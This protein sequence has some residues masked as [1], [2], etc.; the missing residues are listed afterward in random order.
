MS[1]LANFN[2]YAQKDTFEKE[3]S[4]NLIDNSSISFIKDTKQI[5]THEQ[6]Y[7]GVSWKN[8]GKDPFNGYEYVDMGD[9]GIWATCNIGATQPHEYG[10]YFAWGETKGYESAEDKEG[11]FTWE[12]TPYWVS[13]TTNGSSTKWSKYTTIDS[14]S[15]IGIA[16][17]KLILDLEDDAAH[18]NMG[19]DWRMPTRE[20]FHK[21]YNA[22]GIEWVSNYNGT[23]VNGRIFVL[24][25]DPSKELFFPAAGRAGGSSMSTVGTYGHYWSSSLFTAYSCNAYDMYFYSESV[26]PEPNNYRCDGQSVRGFI[27]KQS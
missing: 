1:D 24:K 16:D 12:T 15:S 20:E 11:G 8:I 21:L 7:N 25:T 3:L 13:G 14:Y 17:N 9:A 23:G 6:F 2:H 18:I 4:E 22:C 26:Y 27:P 5:Y 19:G 10:L